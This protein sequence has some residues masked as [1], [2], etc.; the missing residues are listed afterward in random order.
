MFVPLEMH[1]FLH[2]FL[3]LPQQQKFNT[4]SPFVGFIVD[5]IMFSVLYY[6]GIMMEGT[7][8]ARMR[9]LWNK[10]EFKT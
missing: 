7:Q 8:H 2:I 6:E 4:V 10:K 9:L 3:Q 5:L 1:H